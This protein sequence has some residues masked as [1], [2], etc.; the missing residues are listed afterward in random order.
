[1]SLL[2]RGW[3]R[4]VERVAKLSVLWWKRHH[5]HEMRGSLIPQAPSS[6][7]WL[8]TTLAPE[9]RLRPAQGTLKACIPT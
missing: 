5:D 1:M 3:W 8:F 4:W 9:R 6:K 7:G 2:Q